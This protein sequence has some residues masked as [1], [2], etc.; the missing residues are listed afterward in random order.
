MIREMELMYPAMRLSQGVDVAFAFCPKFRRQNYILGDEDG[1][2]MQPGWLA[3][4]R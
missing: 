1:Y 2:A 4:G 3:D